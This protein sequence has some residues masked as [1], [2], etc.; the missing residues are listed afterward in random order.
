MREVRRRVG[1]EERTNPRTVGKK[2]EGSKERVGPY[3]EGGKGTKGKFCAKESRQEGINIR[4][5][6]TEGT[7]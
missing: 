2:L 6:R 4:E 7:K 3:M 5:G 1:R